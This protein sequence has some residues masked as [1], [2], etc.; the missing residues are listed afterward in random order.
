MKP[1]PRSQPSKS[2]RAVFFFHFPLE[3]TRE[4]EGGLQKADENS[5]D[6]NTV[7]ADNKQNKRDKY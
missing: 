7:S 4:M 1:W 3:D 5:T 2:Q 6:N